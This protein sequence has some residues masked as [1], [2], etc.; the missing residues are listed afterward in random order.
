MQADLDPRHA[1]V[2]N[3]GLAAAALLLAQIAVTFASGA[4]QEPLERVLAPAAYQAVLLAHPGALRAVFT[5]DSVF[6][7][8]Y[9]TFFVQLARVIAPPASRARPL[10]AIAV[11]AML[12]TALLDMIENQHILSLLDGAEHGLVPDASAIVWQAGASQLKFH[13]SYFAVF[14]F[15]LALP[16]RT[17]QERLLA[18]SCLY[19][20]LPLG[21]L[22]FVAPPPW[23]DALVYL[24]WGFY[25]SGFVLLGRGQPARDDE[26]RLPATAVQ[27]T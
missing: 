18:A 27:I 7:V 3:L 25:L 11:A 2:R 16:R 12:G 21:L 9:A 22:A 13:L 19:L 6:L 20:Q 23:Q 1:R 4:A 17:A 14:L 26:P 24:R 5:L 8:L 15:G 10:A